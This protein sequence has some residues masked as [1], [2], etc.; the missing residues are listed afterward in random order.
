MNYVFPDFVITGIM[1]FCVFLQE[2][3]HIRCLKM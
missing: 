1:Y 2:N 3:L